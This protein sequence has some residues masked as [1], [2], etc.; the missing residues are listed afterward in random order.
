MKEVPAAVGLQNQLFCCACSL[1]IVVTVRVL[2]RAFFGGGQLGLLKRCCRVAVVVLV[3]VA[4]ML[5]LHS[6]VL[7]LFLI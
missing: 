3:R 4:K 1:N 5:L 2:K 6:F 7:V